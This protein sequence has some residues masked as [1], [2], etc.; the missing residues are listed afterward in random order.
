V[1]KVICYNATEIVGGK[2]YAEK[3]VADK[4]E[5]YNDILEE[6]LGFRFVFNYLNKK[7]ISTLWL[8]AWVAYRFAQRYRNNV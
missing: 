6:I 3:S 8:R 1:A 7:D 2:L 5:A 4:F